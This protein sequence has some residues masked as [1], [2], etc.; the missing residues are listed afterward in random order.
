MSMR[1]ARAAFV[2]LA[3][4]VLVP[5][6]AF[7]QASLT[8]VV[9]DPSGAV[10]PGV[11]VEVSSPELIEKTRTAT[12]DDGGRY[13]IVDLRPGAYTVTFSLQGFNAL[14][15]EGVTL[16]GSAVAT[17]DAELKVGGLEETVTV[18]GETPIVDVQS[19]RRQTT[20]D[21]EVITSLPVTR[22]YGSLMQLMPNTITQG[23]AAS[24]VQTAPGMVV[25]GGA[26]GRSN[27]GRLNIDGIS[28]GSAFNG[29][30]VSSYVADIGNSREVTLTASGG[31]GENEGGGPSLNIVPKEGGNSFHGMAYLSGVSSGMI[32]D[33][34][35]TDLQSRGLTIPG[36]LRKIWDFSGGVGGPILKDRIWFF[37]TAREE[38]SER[39]VPGMFANK[40]AGDPTKFTYEAD[41]SRPA[42]LAQSYRIYN[43]RV[44]AQVT[45]RNKVSFYWDEQQPCEGGANPGFGGS[46]CRKSPSGDFVYGGSTAPPTPSA[47]STLA[48]ET[49]AYRDCCTRLRQA[50]W[51]SPL[52]SHVFLE[53][54][55]GEY[56]SYYGGK[57]IP[58]DNT[59]DLVRI[60][61]QCSG[62]NNPT[63]AL[64]PCPLN[65]NIPN[66]TYRSVNWTQN[67][68]GNSQ[69]NG[70]A[71]FISSPRPS[72]ST[73]STSACGSTRSTRR[74]RGRSA[75]PPCRA[76][77]GMT[78][79]GAITRS[80]RWVPASSS[81][82]PRPMR[83]RKASPATTTSGRAPVWPTTC[84]ATARRRS[85]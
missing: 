28:V 19:T 48:P 34:F 38:G 3:L 75:V 32:G 73:G 80:R 25:F 47:S 46:A 10:L 67:L 76:E 74:T 41:P 36:K 85:R 35:T 77:S 58:G 49:A 59:L 42:V 23:G 61:E 71:S 6:A 12:T 39:G 81:R 21:N 69:W 45:P 83:K 14:K 2:T 72:R 27:E 78:T 29:A 66:L 44:T 13:R 62:A 84:S 16:Q 1:T 24:D 40:N 8:G 60:T 43:A 33:N 26:G 15:R 11:T 50:R 52:S 4:L 68:N 65:G 79:P 56:R 17:V 37:A 70:A 18:T 53:A 30:G 7:A 64:G 57:P 9:K 63:P 5:V 54:G 51:S 31:M 22:S 20:I 82:R 55:W